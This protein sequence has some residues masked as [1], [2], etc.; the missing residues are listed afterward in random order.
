[1]RTSKRPF[2]LANDYSEFRFIIIGHIAFTVSTCMYVCSLLIYLIKALY[3][4]KG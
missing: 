1:M 3:L 2:I 4:F